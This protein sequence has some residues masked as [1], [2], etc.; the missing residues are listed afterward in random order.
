MTTNRVLRELASKELIERIQ[1]LGSFV[2]TR[3][4]SSH[5]LMLKIWP[6]KYMNATMLLTTSK[7][8]LAKTHQMRI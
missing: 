1:G 5:F 8:A 7:K 6:K 4:S 2:V 3:K